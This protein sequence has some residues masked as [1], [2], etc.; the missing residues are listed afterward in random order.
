M[1][2]S[3]IGDVIIDPLVQDMAKLKKDMITG[4]H[5][6]QDCSLDSAC[7]YDF[8]VPAP[9]GATLTDA[10][11]SFEFTANAPC[12][13]QDGAFSFA[14]NGGCASQIYWELVLVPDRRHFPNQSILLS[15]GAGVATCL[16]AAGLRS[17][18]KYSFFFLFL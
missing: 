11:F 3:K 18:P 8:M 12:V 2:R 4:S 13:D 6:N 16:P 7:E 5:S 14:I 15:N 9:P 10:M 17:S 1:L